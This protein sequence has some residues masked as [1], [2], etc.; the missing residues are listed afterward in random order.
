VT[1]VPQFLLDLVASPPRAGDGVHEWI[2]KVSRQLHAH[3]REEE[4]FQFLEASLE[5]C[6]RRVPDRELMAAVR[7][8]KPVAWRPHN[9]GPVH[10]A[11]PAWQQRNHNQIDA[12]VRGGPGLYDLWEPAFAEAPVDHDSRPTGSR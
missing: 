9:G 11:Q 7:N 8:S 12:L 1:T 6:G 5:D 10:V 3:R 4:I 2:F